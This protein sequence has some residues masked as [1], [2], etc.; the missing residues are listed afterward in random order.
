[1]VSTTLLL[2]NWALAFWQKMQTI[3]TDSSNRRY[4]EEALTRGANGIYVAKLPLIISYINLK[5]NSIA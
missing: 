3:T 5:G 4:V 2:S 1:M